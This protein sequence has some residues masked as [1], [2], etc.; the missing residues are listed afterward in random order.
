DKALSALLKEILGIST[1]KTE[2]VE[3]LQFEVTK[4]I[5]SAHDTVAVK[6]DEQGTELVAT[7]FFGYKDLFI[8]KLQPGQGRRVI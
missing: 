3:G 5:I 8:F 1:S 6:L 2:R 7:N 4:S